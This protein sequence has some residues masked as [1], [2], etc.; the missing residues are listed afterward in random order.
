MILTNVLLLLIGLVVLYFGAEYLVKGASRIAISFGISQ[1][2]VGLT[3]VAFATSAPEFVVSLFAT[4]GHSADMA[5]GNVVGSNIANIALIIGVSAMILPFPV[6]ESVPRRDYP[7]LFVSAFV[8]WGLCWWNYNITRIEGVVLLLLLG[9]FLF[10][11]AKFAIS[12]NKEFRA[13]GAYKEVPKEVTMHGRNAAFVIG[14]LI[15][16]IIGAKLMVDNAS[17]I[18]RAFDISE[19]AI[20]V[21]IVALGTSLPELA[22]S[23]VAAL[24]NEADISVGNI[25]G[26]CIFNLCFILGGVSL[27]D[28]LDVSREA[29]IFDFPASLILVVGLFPLIRYRKHV[30][31]IDGALLAL[32]YALYIAATY[33]RVSGRLPF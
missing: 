11:C 32:F 2:V 25:V 29:V 17:E 22:T 7:F 1:L 15:G 13:S 20:G 26:S 21:T 23:V 30:N 8:A 27:I 9:G 16:L 24:R 5:I 19:L 4:L 12:Q 18:A 14:G 33:M 6:D 28:P 10:A 3:V 31:R